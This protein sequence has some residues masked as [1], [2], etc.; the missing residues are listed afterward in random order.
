MSSHPIPSVSVRNAFLAFHD[1]VLFQNLNF[2]LRV[3]EF[4]C[5]LGPSGVGKST[6]LRLIAGLTSPGSTIRADVCCDNQ[7]PLREQITYMAQTD[8]L[9]PWLNVLENVLLMLRLRPYD[10]AEREILT[11]KAKT[12]LA[13]VGLQQAEKK[14]PREL[15]G[16]MRQRTAL[17]RALMNDKP[18][19]LMDEPFSA[20]DAISRFKLQNL[21]AELLAGRTVFLVTHDPLEALRL[22]NKIYVMSGRPADLHPPLV[23]DTAIPRTPSAPEVISLQAKLFSELTKAHEASA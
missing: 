21:A 9:L 12:L 18:I 17:V 13:S 2:D 15:S 14:F 5:L 3:G 4:T 6:L 22:G 10:N 23:L 1:V 8:L 16:G 11:A 19:V 20:L 7:I